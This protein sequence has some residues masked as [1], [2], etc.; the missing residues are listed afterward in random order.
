MPDFT[1]RPTF[2]AELAEWQDPPL[3]PSGNPDDPMYVGGRFNHRKIGLATR[4][5]P[6]EELPHKFYKIVGDRVTLKA[7]P[8]GGTEAPVDAALSGR[9]FTADWVERPQACYPGPWVNP[10]PGRSSV[11]RFAAPVVGHY[12][13]AVR[14]PGGGAVILHFDKVPPEAP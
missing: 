10:Q 4:I 3:L 7:T 12:T 8:D 5:R 9:F 6:L 13:L 14:R 2:G 1:V 11:I